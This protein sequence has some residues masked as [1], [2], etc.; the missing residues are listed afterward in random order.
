MQMYQ[1]V[2]LVATLFIF[3]L[4]WR[5]ACKC[6]KCMLYVF[7]SIVWLILVA[8][9]SFLYGM[10]LYNVDINVHNRAN[11]ARNAMFASIVRS[12]HVLR[13]IGVYVWK[14]PLT[15]FTGRQIVHWSKLSS[16]IPFY[17]TYSALYKYARKY[18][19]RVFFALRHGLYFTRFHR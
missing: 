10:F 6:I 7:W 18:P 14:L 16:Y 13:V 15:R 8:I 12:M 4:K 9:G 11:S 5:F 1:I 3:A 17:R 2:A 19:Y